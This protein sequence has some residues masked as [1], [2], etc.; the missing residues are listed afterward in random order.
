MILFGSGDEKPPIIYY[1]EGKMCLG[2][3]PLLAI[4]TER[5]T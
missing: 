3:P 2:T 5:R 1:K 4:G